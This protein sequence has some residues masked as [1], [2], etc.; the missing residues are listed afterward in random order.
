LVHNYLSI[1]NRCWISWF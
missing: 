1:P